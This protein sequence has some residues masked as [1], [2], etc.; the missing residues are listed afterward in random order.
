MTVNRG[1]QFE[2]VIKECFKK[3]DGVSI[4]RLPD[5][6]NGFAGGSNICD[7]I[8]YKNPYEYYIECKA[9]HGNTLS[10]HSNDPKRKYGNI[11][12]KQFDG[13]LE[14]SKIDGVSAGVICWWVDKDVTMWLD[15][16]M[17]RFLYLSGKKS[18]RFD[19]NEVGFIPLSGRKKKIFYDYDIDFFLKIMKQGYE[20]INK[21]LG[22]T[23]IKRGE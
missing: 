4:D 6:T 23:E 2:D 21:S 11:S 7:F 22:N 16:R 5:Q 17:L 8:A 10:I 18:I 13:L 1:K 14:K 15:I 20:N 3:V 9:V 19:D 12:N